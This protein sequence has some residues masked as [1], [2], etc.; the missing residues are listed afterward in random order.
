LKAL[1]NA[2]VE[3]CLLR[4]GP[5]DL[6]A[7]TY[8]LWFATLLNLLAGVLMLL[9]DQLDLGQAVVQSL[10]EL[11]LMLGVLYG[12]LR[13]KGWVYRFNQTAIALMLSSF[14]LGLLALPLIAW[15]R[16]N[17]SAE[18]GILLLVLF[19]WGIVVFGHILRHTFEFSINVGIAAALIYTLFVWNLLAFVFPV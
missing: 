14:L 9:D 15:V 11:L 6:P 3:I 12:V 10:F 7:S 1:I 8:L 5:Q 2:A 18:A 4:R 16:Q 19:T 17:Q 13:L